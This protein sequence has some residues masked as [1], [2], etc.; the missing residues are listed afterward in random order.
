MRCF[1]GPMAVDTCLLTCRTMYVLI[2]LTTF[3]RKT[4]G[5]FIHNSRSITSKTN[6]AFQR[7]QKHGYFSQPPG[8]T[9]SVQRSHRRLLS[10][11]DHHDKHAGYQGH[12]PTPG[13]TTGNRGTCRG[14]RVWP[15][16]CKE[17]SYP[18]PPRRTRTDDNF[19]RRW[20]P[21]VVEI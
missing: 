14:V 13:L 5:F 7:A 12:D 2:F 1:Q 16:S 20:L 15:A 18:S 21:L 3:I 9:K 11:F 4:S 10:A 17:C 19:D 8:C 6:K